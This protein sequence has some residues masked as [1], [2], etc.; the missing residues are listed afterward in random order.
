M[1]DVSVLTDKQLE[2]K[3]GNFSSVWETH[4]EQFSTV[5]AHTLI[6]SLNAH[7][8]A[9]HILEVGCGAGAGTRICNTVKPK[10]VKLTAVDIS[11]EMVQKAINKVND[12]SIE[13]KTA[14]AESLPFEDSSFDR[15]YSSY[16]LHLVHNPDNM[17]KEAFR[18]LKKGSCA[19][20]SVWGRKE[21]SPQMT[22][23]PY[24]AQR[25]LGTDLV[26]TPAGEP[27]LR[28]A[29]HLQDVASLKQRLENAG[30]TKVIGWYQQAPY[31]VVDGNDF[32]TRMF[33]QP[34]Y[35]AALSALTQERYEALRV[36]VVEHVD[37]ILAD[38]IPV[39]FEV[40]I[41]I[42]RKE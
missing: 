30:F 28:S 19:A 16:C 35:A 17:L 6:S 33:A 39:G 18:V 14:S 32:A 37:A 2:E 38:G 41:V 21:H 34:T 3:W 4:Y 25:V 42:G 10:Q 5:V 13:F 24:V 8:N 31:L 22:I 12:K 23:I 1:G 15:Y 27:P 40:L 29:F 9:T 7:N 26:S 11:P 20:F 36:G